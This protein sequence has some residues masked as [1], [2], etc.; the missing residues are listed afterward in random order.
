VAGTRDCK[1]VASADNQ[2]IGTTQRDW[3]KSRNII[4]SPKVRDRLQETK[5]IGY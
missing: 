2:L 4:R 5:T 3:K 1:P